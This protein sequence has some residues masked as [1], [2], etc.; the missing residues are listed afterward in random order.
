MP[1]SGD[2]LETLV[3]QAEILVNT[4]GYLPG[5]L[6]FSFAVDFGVGG[7]VPVALP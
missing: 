3:K 6:K 2:L 4:G 7:L 1:A 5:T